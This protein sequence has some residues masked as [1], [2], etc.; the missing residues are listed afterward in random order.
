MSDVDLSFNT[1]TVFGAGLYSLGTAEL[2]DVY[3]EYNQATNTT[4]ARGGAI[5]LRDCTVTLVS[6]C[7]VTNNTCQATGGG[8]GI[9]RWVGATFNGNPEL[10]TINDNSVVDP[11]A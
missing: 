6:G 3:M 5:Y 4:E 2:T 1:C 8:N 7:T 9:C 10:N 11:D